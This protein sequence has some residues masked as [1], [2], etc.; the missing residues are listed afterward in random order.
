MIVK[1]DVLTLLYEVKSRVFF[2]VQPYHVLE[3]TNIG[4]IATALMAFGFGCV[5]L[6]YDF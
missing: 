2:L 6:N 4:W 3:G 1:K 5:V